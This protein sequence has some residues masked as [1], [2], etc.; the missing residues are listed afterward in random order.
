MSTNLKFPPGKIL[1]FSEGCYSDFGYVGQVVTLQ[2]VDLVA[3][4]KEFHSLY[5]PRHKYDK[6]HA[7]DFVA[8][9]CAQ[10]KCAG[11]DCSEVYCGDYDFTLGDE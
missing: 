11:L 6:P 8:W 5:V 1:F 9:L 10:Q 4:G 2:D 7:S 3:L